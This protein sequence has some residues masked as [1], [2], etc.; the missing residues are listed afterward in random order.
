[1]FPT[2]GMESRS[3]SLQADSLLSELVGKPPHFPYL[4]ANPANSTIKTSAISPSYLCHYD[5]HFGIGHI[6]SHLDHCKSLQTGFPPS[7]PPPPNNCPSNVLQNQFLGHTCFISTLRLFLWFVFL[8][9]MLF[10][11]FF[12]S[13]V[14]SYHSLSML[15]LRSFPDYPI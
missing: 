15:P 10:G 9:R 7:T 6:L 5:C 12:P 8:P 4:L 1:M 2:T 13:L 11:F 14:P 3:P